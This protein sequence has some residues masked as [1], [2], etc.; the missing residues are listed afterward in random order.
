MGTSK[1][2]GLSLVFKLIRSRLSFLEYKGQNHEFL[3]DPED[4]ESD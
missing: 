2:K 3:S 4:S 1:W